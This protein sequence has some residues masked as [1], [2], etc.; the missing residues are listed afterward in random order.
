MS[1]GSICRAALTLV[2]LAACSSEPTEPEGAGAASG[3]GG[4]ESGGAGGADAE[5]VRCEDGTF[6]GTDTTPIAVGT[7]TGAI[8]DEHG[9]PTSS[10]LVQVCGKDLCIN[11]RVGDDGRLAEDVAKDMDAPALKLGDGLEWAKLGISI[12]EGDSELGTLTTAR[13]PG[14]ADG[15]ALEPGES[16][17]SGGVTLELAANAGIEIDTLTYEEESERTFRAV[18]LPTAALAQLSEEFVAGFGLAPLETVICPSPRLKLENT[19]DL[20]PGTEVELYMQ[21][22]DVLEA[23]APYGGWLKVSE[24]VVAEDGATLDFAEGPPVLT[25]LAVKVKQP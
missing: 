2:L 14:F 18:A 19:A 17:E 21:G 3:V 25:T 9:D 8:V 10:G 6:P 13:L 22:F 7:V 24:G 15:S 16:I 11:A 23:F 20:A 4:A 1:L 12:G 5:P